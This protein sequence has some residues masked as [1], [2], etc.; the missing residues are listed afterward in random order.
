[1]KDDTPVVDDINSFTGNLSL[2]TAP[3]YGTGGLEEYDQDILENRKNDQY[4]S[5]IRSHYIFTGDNIDKSIGGTLLN[6][7]KIILSKGQDKS[8][9]IIGELIRLEKHRDR[10]D[11]LFNDKDNASEDQGG[12]ID[13]LEAKHEQLLRDISFNEHIRDGIVIQEDIYISTT[14]SNDILNAIYELFGRQED[15]YIIYQ[16]YIQHIVNGYNTTVQF[17]LD[18]LKIEVQNI[19][20]IYNNIIQNPLIVQDGAIRNILLE[21]E[22]TYYEMESKI[23][24]FP[25]FYKLILSICPSDI[26]TEDTKIGEFILNSTPGKCSHDVMLKK[27]KEYFITINYN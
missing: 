12:F 9:D 27:L 2:S 11:V 17:Q 23:S 22:R 1:M 4:L 3:I 7:L 10:C 21:H 25:I 18:Q 13:E 16:E 8:Q 20:K 6:I 26:I 15:M 24:E 5:H 14:L 19:N